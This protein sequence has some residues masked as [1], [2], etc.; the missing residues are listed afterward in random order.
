MHPFL[1]GGMYT[2]LSTAMY[3]GVD[4]STNIVHVFSLGSYRIVVPSFTVGAFVKVHFV[5][6]GFLNHLI[7]SC[8][9]SEHIV[10]QIGKRRVQ[11]INAALCLLEQSVAVVHGIEYRSVS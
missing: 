1:L 8:A 2:D 9:R 3:A 6:N 11:S 5:G 10:I 7:N 4:S